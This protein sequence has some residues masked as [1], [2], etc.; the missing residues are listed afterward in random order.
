VN[1]EEHITGE[2]VNRSPE[3]RV[4]AIVSLRTMIGLLEQSPEVVDG[5]VLS[6]ITREGKRTLSVQCVMLREIP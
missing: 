2:L 1:R 4:Q 6:D 5:F 3:A